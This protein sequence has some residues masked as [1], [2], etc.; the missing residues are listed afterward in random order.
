MITGEPNYNTGDEEDNGL[1]QA[2]EAVQDTVGRHSVG[3][4][5]DALSTEE[6]QALLDQIDRYIEF[7][8]SQ[9]NELYVALPI[10]IE[11]RGLGCMLITDPE[12]SLLG[13]QIIE[14]GDKI[15]GFVGQVRAFLVPSTDSLKNNRNNDDIPMNDRSF[16]A[17]VVIDDALYYDT[18]SGSTHNL[19]ERDMLAVFPVIYPSAPRTPDTV[20]ILS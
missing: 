19:G 4:S 14:A 2:L 13:G 17:V 16:S 7:E 1:K 11:V 12:L 8:L 15:S 6:L 10:E 3:I 20:T 5:I 9:S 18:A